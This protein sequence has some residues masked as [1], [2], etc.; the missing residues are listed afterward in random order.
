MIMQNDVSLRY[1]SFFVHFN[2]WLRENE[3]VSV[4]DKVQDYYVQF[5]NRHDYGDDLLSVTFNFIIEKEVDVDKQNDNVSVTS[6]MGIPPSARLCLH[7]DYNIFTNASEDER[8]KI[9]LN[10]ILF[11]LKH[12]LKYLKIHKNTPLEGIIEDYTASLHTDNLYLP[13][14]K[15]SWAF[16]KIINPFRFNFM[17]YHFLGLRDKHIL[18]NTNQIEK[19]LNNN[20]YRIDFGK[21]I[22]TVYFSYDILDYDRQDID[23]YIDNEKKYQYGKSKDLSIMEQYD[24]SLFYD[25]FLEISKY[26]QVVYLH[27]GMLEAISRIKEMKR[28][29]KDF[30][31]DKF[32][33]EIDRLMTQYEKN[34]CIDK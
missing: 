11:L 33:M 27:K 24:K 6:Y 2:P 18:F 14:E 12:W 29:P 28:K 8:Y 4:G 1:Y 32:Y 5:L 30:D 19:Y 21:S 9:A 23:K 17:R 25:E 20:L 22:N 34:Y 7:L 31:V 26:D 10:G 15:T 3:W 16:I 13:E